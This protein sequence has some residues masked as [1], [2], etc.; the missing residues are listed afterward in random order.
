MFLCGPPW[1]W[2]QL[3]SAPPKKQNKNVV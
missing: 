2:V 3:P 1:T